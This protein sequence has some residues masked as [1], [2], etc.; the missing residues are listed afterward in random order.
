M[1]GAGAGAA[2]CRDKT[3][4]D[5][6]NFQR[7]DKCQYPLVSGKAAGAARDGDG[8]SGMPLALSMQK[9]QQATGPCGRSGA[10]AKRDKCLKS[11]PVLRPG[12]GCGVGWGAMK[13]KLRWRMIGQTLPCRDMAH[14]LA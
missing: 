5:S 1:P 9:G 14:S 11:N 3:P 6:R 13:R 2:S 4:V 12:P 10:R 7:S 8:K